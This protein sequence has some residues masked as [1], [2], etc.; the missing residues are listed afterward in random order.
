ML[1]TYKNF[2]KVLPMSDF[3]H[4]IKSADQLS[5]ATESILKSKIL[6]SLNNNNITS[7]TNTSDILSLNDNNNYKIALIY[8]GFLVKITLFIICCYATTSYSENPNMKDHKHKY[9]N[10]KYLY[11]TH[12][13]LYMTLATIFISILISIFIYTSSY[14]TTS[15]SPTTIDSDSWM[16]KLYKLYY[17]ILP[18]A[19]SFEVFVTFSFWSLY[20]YDKS[21]VVNFK[22]LIKG[23][24]T[25][26]IT[27]FGHHLFPFLIILVDHFTRYE[28]IEVVYTDT[29]LTST[30]PPFNRN[31]YL[32][33]ADDQYDSLEED[34]SVA[35]N[36]K[37]HSLKHRNTNTSSSLNTS[38]YNSK[39][40]TEMEDKTIIR[41][42]KSFIHK[43]LTTYILFWTTLVLIFGQ[44]KGKYLYPLMNMLGGA[45]G[46]VIY[47]TIAGILLNMIL[48]KYMRSRRTFRIQ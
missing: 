10:H 3:T 37:K 21:L 15:H 41:I 40:N 48:M 5:L 11:L 42:D 6:N 19:I 35:V 29:I 2:S 45:I 39:R 32:E 36:N 46:V 17:V 22:A 14:N 26:I 12:Q 30:I 8:L 16:Y 24:E 31:A 9:S 20:L 27:E 4:Q 13:S 43:L 18:I 28:H 44:I 38:S 1:F 47:V 7:D 34:D 33:D 23:N 25:P